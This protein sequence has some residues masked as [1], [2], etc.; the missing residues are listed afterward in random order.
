ME[1][2]YHKLLLKG[3]LTG[4]PMGMALNGCQIKEF[5]KMSWEKRIKTIDD[6]IDEKVVFI[7]NS[8]KACF[9]ARKANEYSFKD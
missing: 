8:H 3:L 2:E 1:L 4:C 9:L 6:M 7:I 5:R